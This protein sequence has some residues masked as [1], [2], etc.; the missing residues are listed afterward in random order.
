MDVDRY[1]IV[2]LLTPD[3]PPQ[4]SE[5]EADPLQEAHLSQLAGRRGPLHPDHVPEVD[6]RV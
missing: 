4:L 6:Q 2:L 3:D 1:T 5:E